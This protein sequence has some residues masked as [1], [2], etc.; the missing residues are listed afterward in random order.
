[1]GST[2]FR[3][4]QSAPGEL[5]KI[6]N[7]YFQYYSQSLFW[8]ACEVNNFKHVIVKDNTIKVLTAIDSTDDDGF[9]QAWSQASV[10]K[11]EA[12]RNKC[13]SV[14][15]AYQLALGNV[16][17]SATFYGCTPDS[18]IKIAASDFTGNSAHNVRNAVSLLYPWNGT[19]ST[20]QVIAG[21]IPVVTNASSAP[22]V[23]Q[24]SEW[25]A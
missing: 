17:S 24:A 5:A 22:V 16:G 1:M 7:N 11:L 18:Y 20:Q 13:E 2:A 15:V 25:V 21:A 10:W 23:S 8:S 4:L 14:N 19:G 9:F 6:N 12:E 3:G